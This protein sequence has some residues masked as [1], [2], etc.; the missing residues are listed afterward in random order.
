MIIIRCRLQ[1]KQQTPI[2]NSTDGISTLFSIL[3]IAQVNPDKIRWTQKTQS[4]GVSMV[5][6][7]RRV[8]QYKDHTNRG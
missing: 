5:H 4:H 8:R 6:A 1:L 2:T 7:E 3:R